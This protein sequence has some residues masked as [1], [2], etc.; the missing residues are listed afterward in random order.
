MF[1]LPV[2]RKLTCQGSKS[3]SRAHLD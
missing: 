3:I 2:H 1:T